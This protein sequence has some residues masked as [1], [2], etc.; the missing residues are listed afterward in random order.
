MN[1]GKAHEVPSLT[2]A[3]G[4]IALGVFFGVNLTL[5]VLILASAK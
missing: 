4:H 3:L 1:T 5:L 2:V